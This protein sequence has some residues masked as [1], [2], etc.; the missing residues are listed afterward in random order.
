MNLCR[1]SLTTI[2][3]HLVGQVFASLLKGQKRLKFHGTVG[4]RVGEK[5]CDQG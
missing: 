1:F 2:K 4:G 3:L 5:S